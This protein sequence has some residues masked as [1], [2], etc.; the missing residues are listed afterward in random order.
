MNS[1]NIFYLLLLLLPLVAEAQQSLSLEQAVTTALENSYNLQVQREQLAIA[2]RNN[3]WGEAGRLPQVDFIGSSTNRSTFV[4]P[5]NPFALPG[6]NYSYN[7]QGSLDVQWLLY[8]GFRVRLNKQQLSELARQGQ[9]T[10]NESLNLL[11]EQVITAYYSTALQQENLRVAQ[12]VLS[13]SR[14]RLEYAELKREMGSGSTADL[15]QFRTVYFSDSIS[16]VQLQL[17][18]NEA[19]RQLNLLMVVEPLDQQY[20]LENTLSFVPVAYQTE[21]LQERMLRL[22]PSLRRLRVQESLRQLDFEIAETLRMPTVS[23]NTGYTGA[24][25]WFRAGFP[26]TVPRTGELP[27]GPVS[28]EQYFE[29]TDVERIIVEETRSGYSYGPYLNINFSVPIFRGGQN[30][31]SITNAQSNYQ[32]SRWQTQQQEL[33]L[34]RNLRSALDTYETRLQVAD[35][36]AQSLE[37][38]E[39][40]LAVSE[41]RYKSGLISSF[42]YRQAQ[43]SYN[44]AAQQELQAIYNLIEANA[45]LLRITGGF[46]E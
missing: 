33:E 41:D 12:R 29:F 18:V 21:D 23:L 46:V 44:N 43:L 24:K 39:Q 17:A 11:S 1:R 36:A 35:L 7:L 16:V 37:A 32:I 2:E 42:D 6:T 4:Q 5:A 45:S 19:F 28:W 31:R 13:L 34:Q 10:V 8:N 20:Q 3:V 25:N 9:E 26:Q 22:N 40:N 30:T 27:T 38:A 15:Y 14:D